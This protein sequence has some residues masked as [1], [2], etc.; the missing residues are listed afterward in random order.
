MA[1]LLE[2]QKHEELKLWNPL[3]PWVN[4]E[5]KEEKQRE[6]C[7]EA[8]LMTVMS[9][10]FE[11]L[12]EVQFMHSICCFEAQE[13]NNPMLQTVHNLELKRRSYSHCKSITLSWRKHFAK[14]LRNH[15][16]AKGW[17]RSATKL[18]FSLRCSASKCCNSFI[19]ALNCA[20]FEALDFWLPK[21]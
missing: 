6:I 3:L 20:P 7:D 1:K 17:F 12:S 4:P 21:L 5:C 19:S 8:F 10:T 16:A 9:A 13:V 14:V 2:A 18:A 11:A 15:F